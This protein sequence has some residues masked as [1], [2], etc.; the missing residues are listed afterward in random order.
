MPNDVWSTM[1][2]TKTNHIYFH[3]ARI[4]STQSRQASLPPC[5]FRHAHVICTGFGV[6]TSAHSNVLFSV[7]IKC[8]F[9]GQ[10]PPLLSLSLRSYALKNSYFV[11]VRTYCSQSSFICKIVFFLSLRKSRPSWVIKIGQSY[12]GLHSE[13]W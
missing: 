1:A 8:R 2:A 4:I 3:H 5:T 6:R 7:Y 9:K 11:K 12:C 10:S 13:F